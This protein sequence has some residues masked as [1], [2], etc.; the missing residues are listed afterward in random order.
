MNSLFAPLVTLLFLALPAAAQAPTFP[1]VAYANLG[2][3]DLLLDVHVPTTGTAPFPTVVWI[4]GG[5]WSGGSRAP[6]PG[7]AASLLARGIAV[8]SVDYRLT[9]QAGLFGA[10]PVTFPAQIEDVKGAIRF[11]RANAATYGLDP[12]RFGAWGSSAGGHLAA[13]VGTSGGVASLEGTTGGNLA[14]SSSVQAACDWFGPIDLLR[15]NPDVTTPPG[16]GIDHDAVTSPESHLIGFDQPGQGIGVLRAHEFDPAAPY[17]TFVALANALNPITWADASDPPFLIAHG[18]V[19]TSVPMHQS[20]RLADALRAAGAP[21]VYSQAIGF[22]H[23]LGGPHDVTVGLFF[24]QQ[25]FSTQSVATICSADTTSAAC[26]CGNSGDF[27]HGCMNSLDGSNGALLF[28]GGATPA[29]MALQASGLPANVSCIFLQGDLNAPPVLWGDGVR[30]VNGQLLRL[31]TK[32]AIGGFALYPDPT[33]GNPSIQARSAAAG[34]PIPPGAARFY[35]VYYRNAAAAFC[36][37]ATF[38]ATNGAR[39]VWP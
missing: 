4:H 23:G 32:V 7:G 29:Q 14:F 31:A 36:P 37:P 8:A 38:N 27:G 10:F 21:Y 11:L 16:S 3:R 33:Q 22:G 20:V 26:P 39:I 13:L 30:C 2:G 18:T 24:A 15:M 17:P 34:A 28:A 9:S 19:D 1:N 35:Q 6:I 5:G 12:N 25:F